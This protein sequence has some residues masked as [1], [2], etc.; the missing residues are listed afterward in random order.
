M[1]ECP[2]DIVVHL[3][4]RFG[5]TYELRQDL[6]IAALS[7]ASRT[8]PVMNAFAPVYRQYEIPHFTVCEFEH[9]LIKEHAVCRKSEPELLVMLFFQSSSVLDK[10]FYDLKVHER[11]SAEE[12]D[13][14]IRTPF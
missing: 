11:L 4:S 2:S 9:I 12:I 8:H 10:L 1:R 7:P 3:V 5:R 6:I 13:L 14:E